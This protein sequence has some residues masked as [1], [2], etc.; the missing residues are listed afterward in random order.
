MARC[1]RKALR[2]MNLV[3]RAIYTGPMTALASFRA[4][5]LT[6]YSAAALCACMI[7][8]AARRGSTDPRLRR[9]A[10]TCRRSS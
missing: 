5:L 8:P 1:V 9:F 10:P 2:L 7:P 6:G 3:G 4:I